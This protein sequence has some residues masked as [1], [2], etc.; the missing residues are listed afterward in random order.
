[1]KI[2]TTDLSYCIGKADE[3][4]E[5]YCLTHIA[6][7][8]PE[9]YVD[10]LRHTCQDYLGKKIG[11]ER[12]EI[13]EDKS[14]VIAACIL[15]ENGDVDICYA[16]NLNHCWTRFAIC[17]EIFHLVLDL[18]IYRNM[19]IDDHVAEVTLMFP[20]EDSTPSPPVVA[21]W[22]A[23]F[24]AMEFLFPYADRLKELAG[25][26]ANNKRAIAERY[27]VPVLH[28]ERYMSKQFMDAL[29]P[30]SRH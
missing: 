22:L 30:V 5:Q 1:M 23:E 17:K 6:S 25:P 21:E 10:N 24:A 14:P 16:E 7:D 9:R 12:L 20:D 3:I 15:L 28:V 29:G 26:N 8:N 13:D 27:R 2:K 11:L 4:A 18:E 19:D